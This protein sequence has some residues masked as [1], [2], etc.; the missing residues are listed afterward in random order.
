MGDT[1]WDAYSRWCGA[2]SVHIRPSIIASPD[3]RRMS[4]RTRTHLLLVNLGTPRAAT[5]ESV[6]EF[7]GEFLSDP[8]VVDLPSWLWRPV[9]RFLVL[10][11][12][13]ERVAEAYRSIWNAE[14]SPLRVATERMVAAVQVHAPDTL[15]VSAAYRYGEPSLDSEMQRLSREHSGRI[16][17]MPLF[18]QRT[19]ATTGTVARRAREAAADAR[20]SSRVHVRL[21]PPGDPGY[22][23]ALAAR[24]LEA[25]DS[26]TQPPDHLVV[27]FH[28]IPVRYNTRERRQYVLDCEE[29]TSAFLRAIRWP[30]ARA[31]LA[32]QSKFGPEPWLTPATAAVINELPGRGVRSVAVITPGFLTDG[33]ETLEEIG[34]RA[35]EKFEAKG[36]KVLIRVE[37][38]ED[39][40]TLAS[41]LVRLALG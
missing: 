34:I 31:T 5:A 32:Y 37:A 24:W 23:N 8:S 13:P 21:I 25:M 35:R 2:G 27:S 16:I 39:H 1:V 26:A 11:S 22:I 19:D 29:T 33:L 10:R 15:T 17:V 30:E 20:V 18:P 41:S 7:L 12:R 3:H 4:K 38:P 28:G 9:L 40:H 6:K 14:G 36:G